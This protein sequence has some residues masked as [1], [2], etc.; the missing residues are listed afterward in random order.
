MIVYVFDERIPVT[1]RPSTRESATDIVLVNVQ[2]TDS[3]QTIVNRII[4]AVQ[5]ERSIWLLRIV[6]HGYPGGLRLGKGVNAGNASLFNSLAPYF[7]LGGRGIEL[8]ACRVAGS[9]RVVNFDGSLG[10]ST[11]ASAPRGTSGPGGAFLSALARAT[12]VSVIGGY[13]TQDQ[14][15]EYRWE[16]RGTMTADPDGSTLTTINS[17]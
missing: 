13:D 16:G 17:I 11:H 6:S 12:G 5:N 7:T 15:S 10:D 3:L 2:A 4:T 14:D 1:G 8:H 9:M